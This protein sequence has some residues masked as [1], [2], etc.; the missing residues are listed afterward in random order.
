[1]DIEQMQAW[2]FRIA[3]FPISAL[4]VTTRALRESLAQIK[5][6]GTPLPILGEL[7]RFGEFTDFIGLPE[8]RDLERRFGGAS[9]G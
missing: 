1:V 2:G 9:E 5:Q 4:L 6:A 7:P 8:I 3:I